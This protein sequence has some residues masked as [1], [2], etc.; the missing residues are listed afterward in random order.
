[1][2]VGVDLAPPPV[3]A[4]KLPKARRVGLVAIPAAIAALAWGGAAAVHGEL[5]PPAPPPA[6]EAEP[7][8][9]ALYALHCA[10]CHGPNGDGDGRA[11][12]DPKA[13]AFGK[14]KFK[15]ATTTNGVPCDDDLLR[16]LRRGI[17]GSAM[18]A[19]DHLTE[20]DLR[21]VVG[22]VR[23]LTRRG[24]YAE[25]KR[26]AEDSEEGVFEPVKVTK[27]V[28]E[29][30]AAGERIATP[31]FD[32]PTPESIARGR[33]LFLG[34]EA[35]CASCHGDQGRGDGP[36]GVARLEKLRE[37]EAKQE[38]LEL[39]ERELLLGAKG[40]A[41]VFPR[42]LTTGVF[43]GGR[44]PAHVYARIKLGIP[45]VLAMPAAEKLSPEDVRDLVNY[46]LSLSQDVA[47]VPRNGVAVAGR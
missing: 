13:R 20:A 29:L 45:G 36:Q 24:V 14:E 1:M 41:L 5:Q 12:L 33:A 18:P 7:D 38:R 43:K 46:V 34:K 23:M 42:N 8:G 19:F 40:G 26:I 21:A 11:Q 37:K 47:E 35:A 27:R 30:T 6:A 4:N 9:V 25:L 32:P 28:A 44:D 17:P 31:A 15:L 16:V 10:H 3:R 39:D 22:H 2:A